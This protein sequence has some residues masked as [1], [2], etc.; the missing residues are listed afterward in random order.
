MNDAM[1]IFTIKDCWIICEA[2]LIL[3]ENQEKINKK[4]QTNET[5][6]HYFYELERSSYGVMAEIALRLT[7]NDSKV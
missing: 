4:K 7:Y 5:L 6:N 2:Q 1:I 3:S